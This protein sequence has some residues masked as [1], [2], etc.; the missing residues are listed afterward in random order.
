[1][2]LPHI[3]KSASMPVTESSSGTVYPR[4]SVKSMSNLTNMKASGS[5]T[6]IDTKTSI[7]EKP[8]ALRSGSFASASSPVVSTDITNA[9]AFKDPSPPNHSHAT[10]A[11][12]AI[13]ALSQTASPE[14]SS[15]S[16]PSRSE[17]SGSQSSVSSTESTEKDIHSDLTPLSSVNV[18]QLARHSSS[19]LAYPPSPSSFPSASLGK[20]SVASS[21]RP[22]DPF[23]QEPRREN[24]S[25]S[26]K[27]TSETKRLS[28]AAVTNAAASA[29]N[30]GWNALQRRGE[31]KLDGSF[32]TSETPGQPLVIGRGRPLPPPGTP[33][34]FPDK[35]ST[36]IAVPKRKL[37]PPPPVLPQRPR[38]SDLNGNLDTHPLPP[39]PL[40][41]RRRETV[42]SVDDGLLVVSAPSEPT[43][44]KSENTPSYMRP[45]VDDVDEGEDDGPQLEHDRISKEPPR[46]PKRRVFPS[47]SPEEDSHKL[48]SWLAAQEEEAR[49]R[50]AFVNEDSGV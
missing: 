7:S 45:W 32:E 44:P 49:S 2:A 27:S 11:I 3:E 22:K 9:D 12:A 23:G 36:P 8:R 38:D 42:E 18:P 39:P 35:K 48:P 21:S 17:K 34:P 50:S 6:S 41:R 10:S 5:S 31:H 40:P 46:L 43:T 14:L 19:S 4:K 15:P 13:S 37:I 20:K 30:W 26:G 29:K 47:S 24:S 33:L 25:S 1:M 28:L 16:R